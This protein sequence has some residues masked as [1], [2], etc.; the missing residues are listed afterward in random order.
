MQ[1]AKCFSI[2]IL[3]L[4][5]LSTSSTKAK[6]EIAVYAGTVISNNPEYDSLVLLDFP[7]SL[8]RSDFEF[9]KDESFDDGKLYARIFAQVDLFDKN[10]L[11][12]DS[13]RTYF[14]VAVNSQEEALEKD[15]R[16]FNKLSLMVKPEI[17]SARLTVIDAKSKLSGEYF[18][19]KIDVKA[20]HKDDLYLAGTCLAYNINY[21]GE[22]DSQYQ[23]PMI[24]NGF[25]ILINPIS[26]FSESDTSIYIYSEIFNL[27]YSDMIDSYYL[28]SI[29]ILD[30]QEN[31]YQQLGSRK[32]KKRGNSSVITEVINI[33]EWPNGNY[34]I[35]LS[36]YD[37]S[38]SHS[39]TILVPL[40][41]VSPEAVLASAES[42]IT[43]FEDPYDTLSFH[44]KINIIKFIL[45]EPQ[46]KILLSL[47]D[48]GKINFMN[49][50]WR[51]HDIIPGTTQLENRSNMIKY[52]NYANYYY[53][54]NDLKT[55]GWYTDRGRI[56][57]TYGICDQLDE[58]QVPIIGNAYEVWYYYS[59]KSGGVF[60][61][62]DWTGNDT[63]RLVHSDVFGEVYSKGWNDMIKQ[64]YIDIRE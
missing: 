61:F 7:F 13:V 44:H 40:S 16:L 29:T 41:K 3:F 32:Q 20:P 5:F 39:D 46:L 63:Y 37:F 15:Y 59:L 9:F 17:Y 27:Y 54:S 30:K 6:D 23:S 36:V 11:V 22:S 38:N 57:M 56:L 35:Q 58:N 50:Y 14:S 26:V 4:L 43:D 64:G 49:Q 51:E 19:D 12:A 18:L 47:T 60:V 1:T 33:S 42:N 28:V 8:N 52:Y 48:S 25:N 21:V 31:I 45:E 24:R 55:N 34:N 10:G 53:S 62:E 2:L